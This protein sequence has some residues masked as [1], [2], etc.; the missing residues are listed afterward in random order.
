MAR[1]LNTV[2]FI[3]RNPYQWFQKAKIRKAC[4]A[5]SVWE[6]G[7]VCSIAAGCLMCL[8]PE[9]ECRCS[10]VGHL[11]MNWSQCVLK[12]V[13][14]RSEISVMQLC[15]AQEEAS[16]ER[17]MLM[18]HGICCCALSGCRQL[19]CWHFGQENG[20][21]CVIWPERHS[22]WC[23]LLCP[24]FAFGDWFVSEMNLHLTL[25]R[26]VLFISFYCGRWWGIVFHVGIY[27]HFVWFGII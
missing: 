9:C 12:H 17:L 20:S 1:P 7:G 18:L 10:G 19:W 5:V 26:I 21:V 14:V 27:T 3:C 4:K 24:L 22:V 11:D 6:C 13:P 23:D 16:S 8:V 15:G 25:R 2:L